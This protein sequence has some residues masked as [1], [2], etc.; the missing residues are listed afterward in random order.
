MIN[1]LI[2]RE[3][4]IGV[5]FLENNSKMRREDIKK[6]FYI[7]P[8][9][10]MRE[11]F[12]YLEGLNSKLIER[13]FRLGLKYQEGEK[14]HFLIVGSNSY[15]EQPVEIAF[16]SIENGR[17]FFLKETFDGEQGTEYFSFPQEFVNI[18]SGSMIMDQ[19][20]VQENP[21]KRTLVSKCLEQGLECLEVF[22]RRMSELKEQEI[23]RKQKKLKNEVFTYSMN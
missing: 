7:L 3:K 12:E 1:Q 18:P 9:E 23:P 15:F 22:E 5:S 10:E 14:T 2:M 19:I 11:N 20:Q 13:N 4:K 21:E 6:Y 16:G 8:G 17:F